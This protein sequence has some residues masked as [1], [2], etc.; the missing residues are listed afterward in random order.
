MRSEHLYT[1]PELMR[2][3]RWAAIAKG[4]TQESIAET[5][6]REG[7][8]AM[9]PQLPEQDKAYQTERDAAYQAM[10]KRIKPDPKAVQASI[11]A[12]MNKQILEM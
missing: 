9:M 3:L 10:M 2:W 7:L 5:I 11:E 12:E 6:L 1:T 8:I 4:L